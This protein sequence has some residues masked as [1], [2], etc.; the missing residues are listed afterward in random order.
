MDPAHDGR[1]LTVADASGG[2]RPWRSATDAYNFAPA[3][4]YR[5]PATRYSFGAFADYWI[6]PDA[7][8]YVE[9]GFHDDHTVAQIAESGLFG[10]PVTVTYENPLLSAQ[11]RQLLRLAKPGDSIEVDVFRRNV[12]G[13]ARQSD[14]QHTSFRNVVGL[15]GTIADPWNYDAY[16]QTGHVRYQQVYLNDFSNTRGVRAMDVV[17]D[18]ATG[19]P[20]CRSV[21]NGSDPGCVPYNIWAL[22]AVTQEA[23]DY[24]QTPGLMKGS[25]LQRLLGATASADLGAYGIQVPGM[26]EGVSVSIGVERRREEQERISDVAFA[27]GDLAGQGLS[28]PSVSGS[29]SVGEAFGEVRAPLLDTLSLNA[30]YRYSSYSTG[31]HMSTFGAGFDFAP[32]G[33]ARLRGSVQ[34]AVRAASIAELFF[35]QQIVVGNL[36]DDPCDG[37]TPTRSLEDCA[38]TGVTA[39]QYGHIVQHPLDKGATNVRAGGNPGLEPETGN[40]ITLGVVLTPARDFSAT[41]DYFNLRISETIAAPG[42]ATFY[43]CLNTGDPLFCDRI[44]RDPAL[45]TLWLPGGEID[46]T[47]NNL[48]KLRT[49]GIDI[50]ISYTHRL[51]GFGSVVVGGL[52]TYLREF[53][54]EP[55]RGYGSFDCAGYFASPCYQPRPQWRHRLSA[56]WNTPWDLNVTA[57]WRYIDDVFHSGTS[58]NPMMASPTPVIELVRRLPAMNYLDLSASWVLDKRFTLRGGISNALDRDPPLFPG[59]VPLSN[60]NTWV[61]TYDVLGRRIWATLTANF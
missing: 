21:L 47:P 23:L 39:A 10:V 35:P 20:V 30:S 31:K 60:G 27:T 29:Y 32:A 42:T 57:T 40:T 38:R 37:P 24:L 58:S 51:E 16:L 22:G 49:S 46:N 50:G 52:G 4:Y 26:R 3:N 25:V 36:G 44:H 6:N 54:V 14:L 2:V 18:P 12:E 28:T 15:K 19:R 1:Q 8:A 61:G 59:A 48:G 5:R 17:A 56:T 13:G 43:L 41:V 7:N 55:Y 34:R 9:L 45:G 33:W 11:W 53:V